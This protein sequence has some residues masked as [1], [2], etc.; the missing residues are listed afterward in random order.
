MSMLVPTFAQETDSEEAEVKTG[1]EP[2]LELPLTDFLPPDQQR[3]VDLVTRYRERDPQPLIDGQRL[4]YLFGVGLPSLI[5]APLRICTL[6]LAPGERIAP[7]GV[8][9]GDSTRWKVV[10][11]HVAAND[12]IHLAFKPVD[13]GLQTS[14]SI[15]TDE[16]VYHIDLISDIEAYMPLVAFR[17]EAETLEDVNARVAEIQGMT[18]DAGSLTAMAKDEEQLQG[19]VDEV[20]V[21]DLNFDYDISGCR[22]CAWR[23]ERVFDDGTHTVIVLPA[24][25]AQD[26]LPALLIIGAESDSQIS[27]YRFED[28]RYVVDQLFRDAR[29]TLGVGRSNKEV[30]IKRRER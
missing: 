23:P 1:E 27:N 15:L 4:T 5:C 25:A 3:R 20:S 22:D 12:A 10:Q 7:N 21:D 13:V 24:S 26:P 9:L 17:Y 8:L 18:T 29:L 28:D 11:V 16:R 6:A 30:R 14:L 2:S 19:M